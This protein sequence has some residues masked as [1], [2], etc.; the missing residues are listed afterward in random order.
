M[1]YRKQSR[2]LVFEITGAKGGTNGDQ[3]WAMH[4]ASKLSC[5][6]SKDL[7][8]SSTW[9]GTRLVEMK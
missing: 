5:S 4:M 1:D 6:S 7:L 8:I 9:S 2:Q 3:G